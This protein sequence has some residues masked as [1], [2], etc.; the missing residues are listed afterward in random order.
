MAGFGY[1]WPSPTRSGNES[2]RGKNTRGLAEPVERPSLRWP[3]PGQ[4]FVVAGPNAADAQEALAF[5]FPL[6]V[7]SNLLAAINNGLV[8]C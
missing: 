5:Q 8:N 7:G 4:A 3:S 1:S 2:H 6:P